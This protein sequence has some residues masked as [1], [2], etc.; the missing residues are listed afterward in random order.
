M[1][2]SRKPVTK[3]KGAGV[4]NKIID[5]LPFELHLPGG[6]NYCGPGTKLKLRLDRG[7]FCQPARRSLQITRYRILEK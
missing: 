5:N 2:N 7:G 6:F 1:K 4:I 3:A